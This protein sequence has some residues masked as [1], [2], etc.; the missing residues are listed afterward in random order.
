VT[1]E[2]TAR[3]AAG[4]RAAVRRRLLP[5]GGLLAVVGLFVVHIAVGRGALGLG[6]V[7]A[8]RPR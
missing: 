2:S 4:R 1:R 5:T 6:D 3:A 8:Q 7:I